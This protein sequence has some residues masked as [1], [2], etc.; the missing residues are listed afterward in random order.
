MIKNAVKRI[1]EKTSKA[2]MMFKGQIASLSKNAKIKNDPELFEKLAEIKNSMRI[3]EK[4]VR[5]EKKEQE[6]EQAIAYKNII[7]HAI[8]R[9][10]VFR[11][12]TIS[13]IKNLYKK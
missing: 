5:I 13:E 10:K 7:K 6:K 4:S 1:S 12:K 8:L 2:I 3:V 9:G 11:E